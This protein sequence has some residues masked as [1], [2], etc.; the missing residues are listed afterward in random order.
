MVIRFHLRTSIC[1]PEDVK[2]IKQKRIQEY[3]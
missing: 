2:L 1:I 3:F